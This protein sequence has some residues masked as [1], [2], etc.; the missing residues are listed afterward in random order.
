M[1]QQPPSPPPLLPEGTPRHL[2]TAPTAPP[3]DGSPLRGL[4]T[5]TS[6]RYASA[7]SPAA[8]AA[9]PSRVPPLPKTGLEALVERFG[10][11]QIG[12]EPLLPPTD[13]VQLFNAEAFRLKMN[14]HLETN[15]T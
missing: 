10:S 3:P 7:A 4:A 6:A 15:N 14:T 13:K 5:P 11:I 8:T 12:L 9:S 2:P 1:P